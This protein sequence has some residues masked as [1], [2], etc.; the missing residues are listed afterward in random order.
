MSG[1]RARRSPAAR[2]HRL[3]TATVLVC[4]A[5]ATA[6]QAQTCLDQP[7]W[8]AVAPGVWAWPG[9]RADVAPHNGGHVSSTL[10]MVNPGQGTPPQVTVV[11]PGPHATHGEATLRAIACRWETAALQVINSHAHAENVLANVA[12]RRSAPGT[13]VLATATTAQ[14]MA[15]RCPDCLESLRQAAGDVALKGTEIVL[16]D[17]LL[18]PGTRLPLTGHLWEVQE[19][20]RAHTLSDLV[21][22]EPVQRTLIAPSLVYRDRLPELAQGSLLGWVA[23]LE[24]LQALRPRTVL[25]VQPGDGQDL[26]RTHGYLCE[27]ARTVWDAMEQGK[28][29]GEAHTLALPAYAS[30]AGYAVRQPFNAQRA[31]RE[32][33]PLWM[34]GA[35]APCPSTPDVGR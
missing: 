27:L 4:A 13:P 9:A 18:E 11:D 30:W 7:P 20:K 26:E 25:G 33:E 5:L 1:W 23:A 21:L 29:A 6:A 17:A 15:Q 2:A 8:V 14:Q 32:L 3:G 31:W 35:A 24:A 34:D 28:T 12:Y 19:W 22:W 16:P 10:V